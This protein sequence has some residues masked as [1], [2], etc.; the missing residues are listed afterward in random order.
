MTWKPFYHR[1]FAKIMQDRLESLERLRQ[2]RP[3]SFHK[4]VEA[5]MFADIVTV[6]DRVTEDPTLDEYVLG[7][8]LGRKH[9]DW[10]R[11]KRLLP[12][13]YRLFFKFF[14]AQHEV[15]FAWLNSLKTLRQ[16]GAKTDAYFVFQKLLTRGD[17]ASS[18]AQL[19][20]SS[21]DT[22]PK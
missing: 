13:R 5:K 10:R 4:S 14:Q 16:E 21:S 6:L 18:R 20:E 15:Y 7:N 1:I 22:L 3:N 9:R 12:P 11:A 8:T 2:A 17:V 19:H